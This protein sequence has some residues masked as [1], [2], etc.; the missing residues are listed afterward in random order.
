MYT[1]IF[2][3][4]MSGERERRR[5]ISATWDSRPLPL[6][7]SSIYTYTVITL[8][9]TTYGMNYGYIDWE[10]T[11]KIFIQNVEFFPEVMG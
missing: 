11:N 9:S 3:I 5:D 4:I 10:I 2:V 7:R 6:H 8:Y 1:V